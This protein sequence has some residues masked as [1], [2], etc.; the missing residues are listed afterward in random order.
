MSVI[1]KLGSSSEDKDARKRFKDNFNEFKTLKITFFESA[2]IEG[3]YSPSKI[4]KSAEKI[5]GG[6]QKTWYLVISEKDQKAST[7]ISQ[8]N[9]LSGQNPTPPRSKTH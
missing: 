1:S 9:A 8:F 3:A 4:T 2:L 5:R 6:K 7:W